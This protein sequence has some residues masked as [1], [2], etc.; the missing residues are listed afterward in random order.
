[1]VLLSS[2]LDTL[3]DVVGCI[4]PGYV[5]RP[6]QSA[7]IQEMERAA[8]LREEAAGI[9]HTGTGKSMTALSFAAWRALHRNEKTV[10]STGTKALQDQYSGKDAA[11]LAKALEGAGLK[12]RVIKGFSNYPCFFNLW[13]RSRALLGEKSPISESDAAVRDIRGLE[14]RLKAFIRTRPGAAKVAEAKF[15]LSALALSKHTPDGQVA[16]RSTLEQGEVP[17]AE[18]AK[19]STTSAECISTKCP[20]VSICAPRAA[21]RAAAAAHIVIANHYLLAIQA[22]FGA[23]L[24]FRAPIEDDMKMS[25]D[26]FV[27]DEAH[28]LP[29][30]IRSMSATSLSA[31]DIR[32]LPPKFEDVFGEK[33][34]EP[35][36]LRFESCA[37]M[38]TEQLAVM[39]RKK[40]LTD[41]RRK[42]LHDEDITEELEYL[43]GWAKRALSPSLESGVPSTEK[44]ASDALAALLKVQSHYLAFRS[45]KEN[46]ARWVE[47]KDF[48]NKARTQ[49]VS[50]SDKVMKNLWYPPTLGSES[51]D[52]DA[53]LESQIGE[54]IGDGGGHPTTRILMSGTL[55]DEVR[56][57]LAFR[58][59]V[60][61]TLDRPF[62]EA[63]SRSAVYIPEIL[64]GDSAIQRLAEPKPD[65]SR[66]F[67][68]TLD[69]K[70]HP[71][72]AV[73]LMKRLCEANGGRALVLSATSEAVPYYVEALSEHFKGRIPVL[74]QTKNPATVSKWKC[75][76]N[77]ILVGTKSYMT[78]LDAPG[79]TCSLVIIDRVPRAP[80][81]PP[82]DARALGGD[83]NEV[84]VGDA[85][86]TLTQA[87]GR[88]I[89][90]DDDTGMVAILDPRLNPGHFNRS[91]PRYEEA[92][93]HFGRIIRGNEAEAL[94]WL[95][96]QYAYDRLG[97]AFSPC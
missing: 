62:L 95:K 93:I 61:D 27:I 19:V 55:T 59:P 90:S 71:E 66:G 34:I 26:N 96:N 78:G 86:L 76:E 85:L 29:S 41:A 48:E 69:T 39:P 57:D 83:K 4:G 79:P 58:K 53:L 56:R 18:W 1:M 28:E 3:E 2:A 13:N 92:Y 30:I 40:N 82:D 97:G 67:S 75:S 94:A 20:L 42:L 17:D 15:F 51:S 32:K 91:S 5:P 25:V 16:D 43:V 65:G 23:P 12:V 49:D 63:Y 9:M 38:L 60:E 24:F 46:K 70:K 47:W 36:A 89:R 11:V 6:A 31:S 50:I 45:P 72:W 21:K 74:Q 84:Y 73:D 88:L 68:R 33:L 8:D 7:F 81:S 44:K 52:A 80:G 37:K 87:V 64:V 35:I 14:E 10:I 77:A 54:Y 22:A